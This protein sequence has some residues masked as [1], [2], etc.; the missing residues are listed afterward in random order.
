MAITIT[1]AFRVLTAAEMLG[2]TAGLGWYV[3]YYS[4]FGDY[5]RV[6]AGII[7]IGIVV[8]VLNRF[9]VMLQDSLIKWR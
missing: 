9:M 1:I 3:K 5:A 8:T 4:D 2:A 6:V 7:L